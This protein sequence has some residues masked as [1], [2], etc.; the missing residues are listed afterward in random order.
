LEDFLALINTP[1]VT[2][3]DI[4]F[5][6]RVVFDIPQLFNFLSRTKALMLSKHVE[7]SFRPDY[8]VFIVDHPGLPH[9][10]TSRV[11]VR[12]KAYDWKIS[13][14]VQICS[15]LMPLLSG[16]EELTISCDDIDLSD[17]PDDL[18]H[19]QWLEIFRPF[20]AVQSL[21]IRRLDGLV[22]LA[23]QELTGE[24]VME[25]LP[26]LRS[27]VLTDPDPFGSVRQVLE[28]FITARQLSNQPVTVEHRSASL[29][30]Y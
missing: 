6:N 14:F 19:T 7:L 13:F 10:Y 2:T 23:L 9:S 8:A 24:S 12:C 21:E 3:T 5:F 18:D 15:Q 16:M 30:Y 4:T 25:V 29:F 22:A 28:P 27:L 26:A 1:V 20:I 17:L 11:N